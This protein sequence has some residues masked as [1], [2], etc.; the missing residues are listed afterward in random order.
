MERLYE[1]WGYPHARVSYRVL[2]RGRGVAVEFAVTEGEPLLVEWVRVE[3]L[4][5]LSPPVAVPAELPLRPGAPYALPR[6][7]ATEQL[8]RDVLAERGHPHA[9]IEWAGD[10][11]AAR[12]RAQVVL[13]VE[14]GPLSYFGEAR[15]EAA[16]PL[17][18]A[19]AERALAMRPGDV[20]R[21]SAL[22]ETERRLLQL[23]IV[24]RA[25]A[26]AEALPG[27]TLVST[28]V[29]VET[30]RRSAFQV[31]GTVSSAE[32]LE[33]GGSWRDR[34]V[35]GGPGMLT[36]S[37]AFSSLLAAQLDGNFPCTAVGPGTWAEPNY[38]ATAAL[39]RP[40]FAGTHTSLL[41]RAS[42]S[43]ETSPRVYVQR[44]VAG[45]VAV[46]RNLGHRTAVQLGFAPRR[47]ELSAVALYF[48]ANHGLCEAGA[49]A[50]LAGP[51]WTTPVQLVLTRSTPAYG[52]V[53]RPPA[54]FELAPRPL[55]LP[56]WDHWLR[57]GA[58][59]AGAAT[60]SDFRFMRGFAD[61]AVS[62]RAGRDLQLAARLRLGGLAGDDVLPPQLR[63]YSGGVRSVR[64][65]EQNLV[66]PKVLFIEPAAVPQDCV[67]PHCDLGLVEPAAVSIRPTGGERVLESSLEL[68][69]W[70]ADRVQLAAFVDHGTVR[71]RPG[72]TALR[73]A[74]SAAATTPGVGARIVTALGPLR[75]DLG[76]DPGAARSFPVFTE[77]PGG[78]V[79]EVGTG[80]LHPAGTA[81]GLRR[82][83]RRLQ[84]HM[85][86]GQPF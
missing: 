85:A 73:P 68:R 53:V 33:M 32:C 14:P 25:V 8:L 86:V 11:D 79:L 2:P 69:Y 48:C 51:R 23:P 20:Y 27:D 70:I 55:R 37:I 62:R 15:I 41:L 61:A 54:V 52:L 83:T 24:S 50:D 58:E 10:V 74:A 26:G 19:V 28:L 38:R 45:E 80:T 5:A 65:T 21:T 12:R 7:A 31:E 60:G 76:Y 84:L 63:F 82:I 13:R 16:P 3:G 18:A 77:T 64:G 36:L 46:S 30:G 22:E 81:G 43:R 17:S 29:V 42:A 66:G 49:I 40:W 57:A 67:P 1:A 34:Y 35:A 39:W 44:G 56:L 47:T 4:D 78:G 6:V 75:L 71:V 72:S 9:A 59:V